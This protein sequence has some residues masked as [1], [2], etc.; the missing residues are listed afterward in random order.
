MKRSIR[1]YS[2][3]VL[4]CILTL[5]VGCFPEDSLEW[6]RDGSW[7]LLRTGAELFIVEGTSGTLTPIALDGEAGPMPDISSDGG[8]IA[9]VEMRPCS[10]VEEGLKL[11]PANVAEMIRRD[12]RRLHDKVLAGE[13][14]PTDLPG[15]DGSKLGS[16]ESYH[17]WVVRAMC[18]DPNASL[19]ARLGQEKLDE[20]RQ[21]EIEYCRLIVADR[22]EPGRSTTVVTMP[23]TMLRPRLS[24]DGRMVAFLI[25]T[26]QDDDNAVLIVTTTDGRADA[27]EVA[28]GVGFGY[29][30]RPDSRA[31]AYVKQDGDPILGAVEER[32]LVAEDGAIPTEATNPTAEKTVCTRRSA[33]ATKQFAGTLFQPYMS[34]VYGPEGRVLF[35]SA[36]V[37]IPTS[38]LDEPR[39]SLFC[40]DRLTGTVTDILPAALR[41]QACESIHYFRLSPDGKRLLVPLESNRFAICPL[42]ATGV[43]YPLSI[44]EGF[45]DDDIPDLLPS[46]KGNDRITC[47]VP[48]TSRFLAG[49]DGKPHHR[50]EIVVIDTNGQLLEVLSTNWPDAAIPGASQATDRWR[51]SAGRS[52]P[53]RAA[54]SGQPG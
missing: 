43:K 8:R 12:A 47:L 51:F 31:I 5:L 1:S 45:G 14:L 17:R 27:I 6:S 36:T 9:Y 24:P 26:A 40:Y 25:P 46:W 3:F 22:T 49:P 44:E 42:G 32:V 35:S 38:D 53:T 37:T 20:C 48:E 34:I 39:N 41:N 19:V 33:G 30:W 4:C 52:A 11:F 29:D 2:L 28:S 13:V 21:R 15:G 23:T 7:G 18:E 10:T 16:E 54:G 50:R